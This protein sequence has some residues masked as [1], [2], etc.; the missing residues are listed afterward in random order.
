MSFI[1]ENEIN[2]NHFKVKSFKFESVSSTQKLV[3]MGLVQNAVNFSNDDKE[4]SQEKVFDDIEKI[5]KLAADAEVNI[6][7]LPELFGKNY[8]S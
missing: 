7:A 1:L 6:L 5:I 2:L 8:L 4:W 3:K